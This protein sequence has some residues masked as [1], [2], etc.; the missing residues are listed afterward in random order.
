MVSL[1]TV[2]RPVEATEP[3]TTVKLAE[4]RSCPSAP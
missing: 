2:L 1:I 3:P 4:R